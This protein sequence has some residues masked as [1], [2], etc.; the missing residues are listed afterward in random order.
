MD[1]RNVGN[2]FSHT[3]HTRCPSPRRRKHVSIESLRKYTALSQSL[4]FYAVLLL[5]YYKQIMV[6]IVP[7]LNACCD[8]G[9]DT[10]ALVF[11]VRFELSI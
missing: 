7:L 9:S 8:I 2:S 11:S 4:K 10:H 5:L 1:I 3:P 6:V